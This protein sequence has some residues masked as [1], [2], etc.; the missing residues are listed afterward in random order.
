MGPVLHGR[1]LPLTPAGSVEINH[2][3][4]LLESEEGGAVVTVHVLRQHELTPEPI[5]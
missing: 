1:P 5:G 4:S 2:A 3:A